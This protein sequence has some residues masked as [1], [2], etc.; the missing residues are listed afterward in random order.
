[1][2]NKTYRSGDNTND[3]IIYKAQVVSVPTDRTGYSPIKCRIQI[4]DD[5]NKIPNDKDLADCFP[6][7]PKHLWTYPLKGEYVYLLMLGSNS[8]QQI[9][10][11]LGPVTDTFKNLDGNPYDNVGPDATIKPD[12]KESPDVGIYPE[13]DQVS[14]QGRQNS[15]IIF[16][17]QEVL[18][19]A[20]KFVNN[21]PLK[22]NAQ[23]T[24]YIQIRYGEPSTKKVKKNKKT[25]IVKLPTFDG[26]ANASIA[27]ITG[28]LYDW[29]VN[30]RFYDKQ[31]NFIGRIYKTFVSEDAAISFIKETFID[32]K[33]NGSAAKSIPLIVN[34]FGVKTS[35]TNF[36]NYKFV[37]NSIPQLTNFDVNQNTITEEK[38]EVV[39]EEEVVFD[40]DSRGS[41]IN[42][43]SDK[44]NI[45]SHGNSSNFKLLDPLR[46]I[47]AEEQL[48]I[49]TEAQPIPLGYNLKEFL[50]LIKSFVAN[51]THA[52]P[53]LPPDPFITVTQILNYDLESILNQNVRTA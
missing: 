17:N 12:I 9:R 46:T 41:V 28:V 48:T 10:Y 37:N 50:E 30:I 5:P 21:N 31:N 1:M 25:K 45:I 52:Y 36:S 19:R 49:N 11:F 27:N 43:V 47:T 18:L 4:I 44:I 38:N 39:E 23:D 13:N 2:L 53:G 40:P 29:I 26:E 7:L 34:N 32:L 14:I 33:D 15:D 24:G 35:V 20:G 6:L 3:L 8:Q 22:F 51:H 16:K 42:I